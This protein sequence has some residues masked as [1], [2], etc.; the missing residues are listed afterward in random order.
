MFAGFWL[1]AA[2]THESFQSELSLCSDPF[3]IGRR[4]GTK[5]LC[6]LTAIDWAKDIVLVLKGHELVLLAETPALKI[7][8]THRLAMIARNGC[9][10][11]P[12][13]FEAERLSPVLNI[14]L[15]PRQ[16]WPKRI[17]TKEVSFITEHVVL[18]SGLGRPQQWCTDRADGRLA[19]VAQ[20]LQGPEQLKQVD[21]A[22]LAGQKRGS[23]GAIS[24]AGSGA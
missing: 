16:A 23:C 8:V 24:L 7:R 20:P 10:E 9:W 5:D 18:D 17:F 19:A 15:Q 3:C 12:C 21:M 22:Q 1:V 14:E 2:C 6:H 13:S 4:S 11:G